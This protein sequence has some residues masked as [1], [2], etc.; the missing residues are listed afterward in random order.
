MDNNDVLRRLRYALDLNDQAVIELFAAG[1][2]EVNR[3]L[4]SNFLKKEDDANFQPCANAQLGA[5]L[6]GLIRKKRESHEGE[7]GPPPL[8]DELDNN[9]V[10]RKLKIALQLQERDLLEL[11]SLSGMPL[12]R[13]ELSALFRKPGHQHY[14][15]CQDQLLR[16]FLQGL[17]M[18]L[19]KG[20]SLPH[21]PAS[22]KP[23]IFDAE[24]GTP[25]FT[26]AFT[27]LPGFQMTDAWRAQF[28]RDGIS[29]PTS[30]QR[31][32]FAPILQGKHV[33]IDS[34]TGTGKTLAYLLP[35]FHLL[36]QNPAA[37]IVCLAPAAE[38]AVQT[39][40]V[41]ERYK[42]EG[43]TVGALLSGGNQ[44]KQ[45]ASV[46]KSTRLIVG[47][48]GRVVEMIAARKLKGVT[49]FVLDEPEPILG[50]KDGSF[51]VEILSRP[52]RPQLVV[53]GATFG[54]LSE[55]LMSRLMGE[56]LVRAVSDDSPLLDNITHYSMRVREAGDRDLQL[57]RFL[58][59]E[60]TDRSIVYVNQARLIRHLFRLL[61]GAGFP[62]VTLSEERSKH[63]C[64]QA[65]RTFSDG[66][67]QV[68]LTTDRAATGID[69]KG[70]PW[71]VHYQP[72]RSPQGYVH[73]AGRTGRA[74]LSG[75][76]LALVT[77]SER[78]ILKKLESELGISFADFRV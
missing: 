76:S 57:C 61:D 24:D 25:S 12:G 11:M 78:F 48:P 47:T 34:G 27:S 49:T 5:F 3:E 40:H 18:K 51:L 58:E 69:L 38:L 33:V 62:T 72:A 10:L 67:A 1:G 21:E 23:E 74:G 30:P 28:A 17:Q 52:P 55:N 77:D 44:N 2:L 73:R 14:R 31:L 66:D 56:G 13:S 41:L 20:A 70:V 22:E 16:H 6:N 36:E 7:S 35:L 46:T 65:L 9:N 60:N 32:A 45:K 54:L 26:E 50:A 68:L 37:R 29:E 63:Q 64:K 71:V 19:R 75:K 59:Q 4:I 43:V 39:L 15:K 53:A 8:E 42:P